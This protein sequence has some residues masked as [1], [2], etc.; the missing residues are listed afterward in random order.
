MGY[1]LILDIEKKGEMMKAVGVIVEYN[2]F[3][4]GHK[5]HLEETKKKTNSDCT[6]AVMSGNFLQRGEPALVSKWTRTKMAL[7]AGVDIVIEL[8]Y[9]FAT[10]KAQN[11]ANG[12]ISLLSALHCDEVCFGSENGTIDDFQNTVD[13]MKKINEPMIPSLG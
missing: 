11:F 12:A 1:A 9:A 5:Y 6:I 8:P 4:N 2:P 7:E 13:F 3:H 10:Q